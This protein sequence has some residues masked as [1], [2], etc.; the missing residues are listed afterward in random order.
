MVDCKELKKVME[1]GF[2]IFFTN[3]GIDINAD[4]S[5]IIK[6]LEINFEE[7]R[8]KLSIDENLIQTEINE[9]K[10]KLSKNEELDIVEYLNE[11]LENQNPTKL[12]ALYSYCINELNSVKQSNPQR[13]GGVNYYA[14]AG[15]VLG[16][17]LMI[18]AITFMPALGIPLASKI[19][20]TA[21]SAMLT[22]GVFTCIFTHAFNGD[23]NGNFLGI[24]TP[25]M[26]IVPTAEEPNEDP[27]VAT[28][29][30]TTE[31]PTDDDKN[32]PVATAVENKKRYMLHTA[33]SI[34]KKGGNINSNGIGEGLK[35][36]VDNIGNLD[37]DTCN[38]IQEIMKKNNIEEKLKKFEN[39]QK[40]E[41]SPFDVFGKYK[42]NFNY[43]GRRMRKV[44]GKSL[45]KRGGRKS[46]KKGVKKVVKKGGR[47]SVR[48]T[49]NKRGRKSVRR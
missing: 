29:V 16:L 43:G 26:P 32:L 12:M 45:K 23:L 6:K 19:S 21:A 15:Y 38:D 22:A 25:D 4:N 39:P 47:K 20:E 34:V 42:F 28:T 31:D 36:L 30:A 8:K 35:S 44:K 1:K 18:T 41:K 46:I 13:G 11:Y 17:G 7:N 49:L 48:K 2:N 14:I 33:S 5:E 9:I 3:T 27:T 24:T 10:S 37:N 40:K